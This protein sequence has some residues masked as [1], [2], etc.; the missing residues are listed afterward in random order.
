M[1]IH[2]S[3]I[4]CSQLYRENIQ[5]A[6]LPKWVIPCKVSMLE[7]NHTDEV[8]LIIERIKKTCCIIKI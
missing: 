5:I 1:L 6:I 3:Y 4:I 8:E 2:I 7:S